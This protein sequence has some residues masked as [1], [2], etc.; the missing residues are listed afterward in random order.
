ME[1]IVAHERE[2][3][4]GH[5]GSGVGEGRERSV[6]ATIVVALRVGLSSGWPPVG[7]PN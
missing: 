1:E 4:G 5:V 3:A 7:G 2:G 6:N